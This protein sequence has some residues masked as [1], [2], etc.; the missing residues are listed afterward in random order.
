MTEQA[1]YCRNCGEPLRGPY[2]SHCGQREGRGDL[3]FGA[4]AGEVVEEFFSWD[5]RVWRTLVPLVFRPGFLT[6]EFIAGRRARYVPPFRL[7]LIISFVLFLFVS[8][9]ARDNVTLDASGAGVEPGAAVQHDPGYESGEALDEEEGSATLRFDLRPRSGKELEETNE[10]VVAPIVVGDDEGENKVNVDF[11]ISLAEEDSAQWLKD[12]DKR[13]EENAEKLEDDPAA[14]VDLLIEYL[15]QMMFLLLPLFA[16][17]LKCCYLFSPFHYLQHLVFSLHFH[18][19]AYLLYLA[20]DLIESWL[21]ADGIGGLLALAFVLYLPLALR[22]TY[23]SSLAGAVGK[24][25]VIVLVDAVLLL[26]GFIFVVLLAL[27]LL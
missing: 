7:Y 8:L 4:V 23:G 13:L 16:L 11:G 26:C 19:F 14:F 15:P 1:G 27:A 5:S 22:R 12:L 20:G 9:F 2:C 17:L 18:S 6:A 3:T 10:L 25:L 21:Y 24:S